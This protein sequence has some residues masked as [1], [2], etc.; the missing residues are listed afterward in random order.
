MAPSLGQTLAV[1]PPRGRKRS[2][3]RV[4]L[5]YFPNN[6]ALALTSLGGTSRPLLSCTHNPPELRRQIYHH[7]QSIAATSN[8]RPSARKLSA[9][10]VDLR[11]LLLRRL[12]LPC[13]GTGTASGSFDIYDPGEDG[14]DCQDREC[15]QHR[16]MSSSVVLLFS[17]ATSTF[18]RQRVH[19]ALDQA[20]A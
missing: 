13:F 15:R 4:S 14:S 3:R 9:K 10:D 20:V 6:D 11:R 1:S 18:P 7:F 8:D 2:S 19:G 12:V 17:F 5:K 16:C